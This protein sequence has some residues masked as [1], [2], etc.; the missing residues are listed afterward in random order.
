MISN[1]QVFDEGLD[2][3]DICMTAMDEF[4]KNMVTIQG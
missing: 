4:E 1:E 2:G 3:D